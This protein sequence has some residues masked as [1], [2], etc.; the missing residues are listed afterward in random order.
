MKIDITINDDLLL[1]LLDYVRK[2]EVNKTAQPHLIVGESGSG[3]TFLL[4]RL[5]TEIKRKPELSLT[6]V[7]VEGR[8]V[9]ST[10]D[11]WRQCVSFLQIQT[12]VMTF[13]EILSWQE[14]HSRRIVLMVDNI[15]Y[16]F[17][18][19]GND[20]HFNLRGKLNRPGAPVVIATSDHVLPVFTDYNAAFFDGFKIS[21]MKP[22]TF[23]DIRKTVRPDIDWDR[24][25]NLMSYLPQTPRSLSIVLGIL[26]ISDDSKTD[27][28]LLKD[29]FSVYC[30]TIY[31]G[32]VVQVQNI[33]S[34][35]ANMDNGGTLQDIRRMT[36][37][38]NGKLSPYLKLMVDK[39]LIKKDAET[40]RKGVYAI[41]DPL[42][43]L[44]LQNN[45]FGSCQ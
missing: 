21:Y 40:P 39:K 44:W 23:Q 9:F 45:T 12:D 18:R 37:Q 33:L 25:E 28:L 11:L 4:N 15:R 8:T 43:K 7:F 13:E 3:K 10:E 31:D 42:L 27:I 16:Y 14:R 17:S 5:F 29:C 34:A 36:G 6:P 30:Q 19:T 32:C 38:D 1:S 2:E 20:A 35:L 26:E 41:V 24:L 22:L